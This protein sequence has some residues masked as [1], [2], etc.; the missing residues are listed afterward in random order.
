[1][2]V[3]FDITATFTESMR[4]QDSCRHTP[5]VVVGLPA[6]ERA[7][8]RV[9]TMRTIPLTQGKVALVDDAD[10]EFLSQWKWRAT[11][12]TA[13]N[14]T[15]YAV[16][17]VGPTCNRKYERMHRLILGL[18]PGDKRECDHRD[19]NGLNNQQD[20]LRICTNRQNRQSSRKWIIG[21]SKYKG[22]CWHRHSHKWGSSIG[23]NGKRIYLGYFNSEAEAARA[24]DAAALKYHGEFALTNERLG[25]I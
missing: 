4:P 7:K 8:I 12:I 19:G 21:T 24:Y 22:V 15:S 10:Y 3:Q 9:Y 20:N 1:M 25:L 13:R 6:I 17:S 14:R 16:R 5:A 11:T 23:I 18:Q 2:R